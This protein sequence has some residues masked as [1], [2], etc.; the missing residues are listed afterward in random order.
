[1][2]FDF[3]FENTFYSVPKQNTQNTLL[4]ISTR[5]G[6]A[7]KAIIQVQV[8]VQPSITFWYIYIHIG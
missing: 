8:Q 3:K 5:N 6:P 4:S 7:A 1:M 2:T